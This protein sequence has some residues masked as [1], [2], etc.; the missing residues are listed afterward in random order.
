[1]MIL[2][3]NWHGLSNNK[4]MAL[5]RLVM[6]QY[7][8]ILDIEETMCSGLVLDECMKVLLKDWN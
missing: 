7:Q 6:L 2:S 1:M 5:V 4:K 3:L 8:D